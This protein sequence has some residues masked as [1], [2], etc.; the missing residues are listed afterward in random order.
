MEQVD[1]LLNQT[2]SNI[3]IIISD[4]ASIDNTPAILEKFPYP[5]I[6]KS[7][8]WCVLNEGIM[9]RSN[10]G[11]QQQTPNKHYSVPVAHD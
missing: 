1:S 3:E 8:F 10:C 7:V 4:D 2:Y 11:I 6:Y 5:T 9:L